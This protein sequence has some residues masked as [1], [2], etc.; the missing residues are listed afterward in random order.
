M[1][2]WMIW[3]KDPDETTLW[4]A[5]AWDDE[6]KD[7]NPS[8]WDKELAKVAEEQGAQN[9]RVVTSRIDFD[10]VWAAFQPTDIGKLTTIVKEVAP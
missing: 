5:A 1:K 7:I 9:I 2:I 4:L 10:S 8:G 6:S 3:V